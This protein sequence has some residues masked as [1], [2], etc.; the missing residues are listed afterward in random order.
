MSFSC[1][2]KDTLVAYVYGDCDADTRGAV[3][4]HLATCPACA[5]EVGGFGMVR[6]TLSEWRPPE[7]VGGLRLVREDESEAPTPARVLRPARWWQ[8]PLPALAKVAAAILLFAGGAALA[9]LEVRYDKDGFLVRTGWQKPVPAATQSAVRQPGTLEPQAAP[10][11]T[12]ASVPG[13]AAAESP[14][15]VELASLERQLRDEFRQQLASVRTASA[16]PAPANVA[17]GADVDESQL[18]TRV[19]AMIDD[20]YRRQQVEMALRINQVEGDF[21][22]QRKADMAR[23]QQVVN[24][25]LDGQPLSPL[26]QRNMMNVIRLNPVS[27]KMKK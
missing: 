6:K 10:A 11:P 23:L 14:W 21:Q 8:A 7:R 2:D 20:S 17:A 12:P 19:R 22:T 3:E 4:A 5:D 15:R 25:S 16:G 13:S 1:T 26:Q 18:M 24:G 27:M 9:N